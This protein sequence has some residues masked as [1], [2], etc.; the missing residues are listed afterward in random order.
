MALLTMLV[1]FLAVA[2][3]ANPV[4]GKKPSCFIAFSLECKNFSRVQSHSCA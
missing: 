4:G 3:E 1:P 2:A